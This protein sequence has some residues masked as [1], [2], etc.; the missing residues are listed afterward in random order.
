MGL[1]TVPEAIADFDKALSINPDYVEAHIHRG[2]VL[3]L[4]SR[5]E[6]A[7]A[8][9]SKALFLRP[10]DIDI[11]YNRGT[12]LWALRRFEETILDCEQVLKSDPQF[13]YARGNFWRHHQYLGASRRQSGSGR[14]QGDH[15][16]RLP[17]RQWQQHQS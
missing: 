4:L 2:I 17:W 16:R 13:K 11:L 5:H 6:E 10:G 9:Y 12:S 1:A 8:S 15:L 3:A 7:I 14:D